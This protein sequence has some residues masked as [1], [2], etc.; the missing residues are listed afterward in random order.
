MFVAKFQRMLARRMNAIVRTHRRG[1][2]PSAPPSLEQLEGRLVLSASPLQN[3]D[4]IVVIY[5]E[6]WSFDSLYG[7]FPGANGIANAV[8]A[9]GSLKVPQV[10]K[11]GNVI[12]TL[13]PVLGP[14]GKPDPRFPT[15]LPVQ[16]YDAV[17][18]L[19]KNAP[20]GD[21]AGLTGDMIHRF[22]TE[23]QQI[24]GGTNDKFV[25][26]SD[27]GGLVLSYIDSTNLPEGQLAQQYTLDDNFF[28]AA[29]GGSFLNH[30]FLVAAAAPQWNQPLPTSSTRFVSTLDS[31][32]AP[33]IDGNLTANSLLAPDGN[34][35]VVNTTQ[36]AQA[37]F[38]PGTP[39]DQL[40]KPINDNHPFNADGTPDPT[41]TP[42]IGDRLDDAGVSWKWY[43]GGWNA[44]LA[45]NAESDPFGG[46]F[47]FH[48]QPFAYYANFAPFN[49]DGTP[50]PQTDS[51]L[52]PDAHLQD[53]TQFFTDLSDGNLPAVSFIKPI[54]A[55]NEH[56]GYASE[57][58]GQQHV[59]DI[60][61]AIQNSDDWAHT[62]IVITYDENGGR[63]DHV[64]PPKLGDGTWGDG[65]RVPAIVIS[66]Y[67]KQGFVDHT[68]QDTLSILKTIE[69]RFNLQPLNSLDANASDLTSALQSKPHVSI[70]SAYAQ[71][72]AN[73]PSKFAL[74]VQGTEGADKINIT[75][76][77][78]E[79]RV[80]IKGRG[81]NFDHFFPQAISRIE[82]YGQG[83]NDKIS[84]APDV[85]TPAYIFAGSGDDKVEGGGGQTVIVGGSGDNRLT[86]GAGA[87]IIIGGSGHDHLATGDGAALLIAGTTAF[88][89]NPE[90]IRALEAEWS[91][92]DETFAQ[93]VAHLNG[94]ATGGKN[95]LPGTN[96]AAILDTTTVQSHGSEDI[97][98]RDNDT[99]VQD[100]IF[101]HLFGKRTDKIDDIDAAAIFNLP[102]SKKDD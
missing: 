36:P 78:G 41:Y 44:A 76:D 16:P 39:A 22:Y 14:D 68:Q 38:R 24:D 20:P 21:P 51:L 88:D 2:R 87:S 47:Q 12:T 73:N 64:S 13:P 27:N 71:I 95:I 93:K 98:T 1:R 65:T 89:A 53:E 17:P 30:Q 85:T 79:I 25:S 99:G 6:N 60:V 59:A 84:V 54:G 49:A 5:Q 74:I 15:N 26:W 97:I 94:G 48:H 90:A 55:D 57:L 101:A 32:G 35:F 63:W 66:P 18:F 72:D 52:N 61:H 80:Q 86:G 56:P 42:T 46:G 3:I 19:I 70:G 91:R 40:L 58:A 33:I 83:G 7:F 77:S 100:L 102:W 9:D 11:S 28:H 82:I 75:Q 69:E 50:N 4:H 81:V 45:G 96:Q 31:S 10:D 37:P 8:N 92:T 29:F 67:S 62:A 23:Q 43:S 34:H